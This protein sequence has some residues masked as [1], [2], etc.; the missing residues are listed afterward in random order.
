MPQFQYRAMDAQ[1]RLHHGRLHASNL[2]DVEQRLLNQQYDLIQCKP[3][4]TNRFGLK[5]L[6]RKEL[7]NM[8]FQLEQLTKAGVPLVDGL[9]DLRDSTEP[10]YYRDT[11]ASLVESI[12]GGKKFSD[13]L[14]EFSHDFDSVFISLVAIGEQSGQLSTILNDMGQ[15]LRWSD[16]LIAKTKKIL[17]YPGIVGTVVFAVTVFLMVYVVPDI[18]TF[19]VNMGAALPGHTRLL[20]AVSDF[21]VHF[22]WLL[23]LLP[24]AGYTAL[25]TL[26][27]RSP[28]LRFGLDRLQLNWPIIG[29]TLFKIK[30][31]RLANYMALLYA[32]GIT[33]LQSLEI[34]KALVN[35][36][37]IAQ[38]IEQVRNHIADGRSISDSFAA[39]GLFPPLVIR[40]IRVGEQTGN[41][42]ESLLNVSYFYGREV[43]EAVDKIEPAIS[44]ILTLIMGVLMGWIMLSVLGPVW[45]AMG[46]IVV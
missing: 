15:T 32:S 18:I 7:I 33:V 14:A 39:T 30:I 17:I 46:S 6:S 42:Q 22:W 1:G 5:R 29:T 9:R 20:I 40:M 8:T 13:A 44:P 24:M 25:Q 27:Q 43:Q 2:L 21:F 31:A 3:V 23:P 16:E 11:L 19:V 45:E 35:N 4:R 38:A 34:C 10:G 41:M 12:E 37:V 28:K 36:A 26:K